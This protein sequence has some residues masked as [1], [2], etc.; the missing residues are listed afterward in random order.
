MVAMIMPHMG[1]IPDTCDDCIYYGCKP[2]PYKGWTDCCEL[3]M[4]CMDDDQEDDWIY[5][6]N[7]RPK[8]CPLIDIKH[9]SGRRKNDKG[10][11]VDTCVKYS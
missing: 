4:Q 8:N 11:S 6:G 7:S 3:C 5:D 10:K 2:H 9:I 1:Q